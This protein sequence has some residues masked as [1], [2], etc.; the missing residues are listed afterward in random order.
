MLQWSLSETVNFQSRFL[1]P[2]WVTVNTYLVSLCIHIFF[3]KSPLS[4][5]LFKN[6]FEFLILHNIFLSTYSSKDNSSSSTTSSKLECATHQ[7]SKTMTSWTM[8]TRTLRCS[9]QDDVLFWL[10]VE[11]DNIH[12]HTHI[13]THTYTH[14]HSL[15]LVLSLSLSLSLSHTH[16]HTHTHFHTLPHTSTHRGL[17]P[18]CMVPRKLEMKPWVCFEQSSLV[19][20]CL[21]PLNMQLNALDTGNWVT[22]N[23]FIFMYA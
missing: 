2:R 16:T 14:T 7:L 9:W 5:I 3:L 4:R 13:Y 11:F 22:N 19:W 20:M 15:S 12:T 1:H 18:F 21:C 6:F 17:R 8:C 10:C 23:F